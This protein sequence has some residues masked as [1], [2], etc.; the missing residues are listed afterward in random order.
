MCIRD[1]VLVDQL[2]NVY[3]IL[4]RDQYL[5]V[6]D[7]PVDDSVRA[8][9]LSELFNSRDEIAF[10]DYWSQTPVSRQQ[11]MSP[12]DSDETQFRR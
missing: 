9:L 5:S 6:H 3:L 12:D 11:L 4:N 10:S 7:L 2:S 1:S 8:P